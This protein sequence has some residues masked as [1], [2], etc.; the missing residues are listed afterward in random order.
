M[1]S[2]TV[3]VSL[4]VALLAGAF[5][6]VPALGTAQTSGEANWSDT[7]VV[8]LS[9]DQ[10]PN[11]ATPIPANEHPM[12]AA[13]IQM[14]NDSSQICY[15]LWVTGISNVSQAHIHMGAVGQE[16]PVVAWLFPSAKAAQG[17][18]SPNTTNMPGNFTGLL[19]KGNI[20]ASDLVGPMQGKNLTD[21]KAAMMSGQLYVN[22]H[23]TQ[24][25]GGEIR[26]QI[27]SSNIWTAAAA[28]PMS[29]LQEPTLTATG[30]KWNVT[31]LT[32]NSSMDAL[33]GRNLGGIPW[34]VAVVQHNGTNLHYG[35]WTF[36]IANVTQAHFH[37]GALGVEGPVVAWLYPSSTATA[38]ATI[39]PEQ[40][41]QLMNGKLIEGNV[42][43][44][45]LVGP[46]QGKTVNDLAS[47][48][49]NG[50]IYVNVHSTQNPG[51]EIRGQIDPMNMTCG[52][53]P[54]A[55][56]APSMNP[57]SPSPPPS[58]PVYVM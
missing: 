7:A 14:N 28:V 39:S 30:S 4:L 53:T 8:P 55:G 17:S 22:V 40:A 48:I 37:M 24:N 44:A 29:P 38:P 11:L 6:M 57:P 52:A 33:V 16:G 26:G 23:T 41:G 31:G 51:G 1:K 10:E 21:L 15:Q 2:R 13:V 46:L 32:A 27:N 25:P 50:S 3:F 47:A 54:S 18:A 36:N 58:N 56:S 42:S 9:P 34:G 35:L 45:N 19:A 5:L 49:G 12:G 43:D 20:S